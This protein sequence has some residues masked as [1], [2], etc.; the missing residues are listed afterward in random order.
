M[1]GGG[2]G[3]GGVNCPYKSHYGGSRRCGDMKMKNI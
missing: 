3:G 2:G 1:M